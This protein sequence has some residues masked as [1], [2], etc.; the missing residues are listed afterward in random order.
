MSCFKT[1][2][3]KRKAAPAAE[4]PPTS[5]DTVTN[6]TAPETKYGK[7]VLDGETTYT[8]NS[9]VRQYD[10]DSSPLPDLEA[11]DWSSLGVM[12]GALL[13]YQRVG[14]TDFLRGDIRDALSALRASRRKIARDRIRFRHPDCSSINSILVMAG[15]SQQ[16]MDLSL[17]GQ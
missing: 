5:T 15:P 7:G 6:E 16:R 10:V 8:L 14:Q 1:P 4:R 11:L 9:I 3:C 17:Y 12:I 13:D 2:N